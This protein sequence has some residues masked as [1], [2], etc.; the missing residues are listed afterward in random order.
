MAKQKQS[1]FNKS[2]TAAKFNQRLQQEA[3]NAQKA[4]A[5]NLGVEVNSEIKETPVKE[6]QAN[7]EHQQKVDALYPF[8]NEYIPLDKLRPANP[9]WNFF[10]AQNNQML[11]ELV[12]NI[13]MYGQTT[14]ARVWKQTDGTY[15]I[16]GGHTRFEALNRLH[17][18]YQSGEVELE[19]DFDTMWC[20]VYDV[21]T[22]DDIEARKIVIYDNTIRR[23]NSNSLLSRSVIRMNQLMKETRPSH[24][25]DQR[26]GR[27][28][29]HIAEI[30]N[31]SP[32]AASRASKLEHLIPEFWPMMDAEG[33]DKR[34]TDSL[35]QAIASMPKELQRY[36]FDNALWIGAK[37]SATQMKMLKNA[38]TT[39]EV[40]DI[41]DGPMFH[42][43]SAKAEIQGALPDG[44]KT[45]VV[46]GN[47]DEIWKI[48]QA[49]FELIN[50]HPDISNQTKYINKMLL[51]DN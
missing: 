39:D 30:F 16:L 1:F 43:V 37:L 46:A 34:I 41:F 4:V 22:L 38:V 14:P 45:F 51:Q 23:N 50:S 24:R 48:K 10:P 17:E 27:I 21:D 18:M 29:D 35:A 7:T 9:E 5:S 25:P 2:V 12:G 36:V 13:A 32:A 47:S 40:K 3:E 49:V 15:M 42:S 28:R 44:Y 26:R 20:S 6:Q 19:H 11:A 33:K 8:V 31:I